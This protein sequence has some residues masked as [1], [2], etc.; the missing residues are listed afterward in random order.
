[1]SDQKRS[2]CRATR[3]LVGLLILTSYTQSDAQSQN[4]SAPANRIKTDS[5]VTIFCPVDVI[6]IEVKVRDPRGKEASSLGRDDFTIYENGVEQQ[7]RLWARIEGTAT[8]DEE[9]VYA[10]AYT[11]VNLY[12]GKFHRIRVVARGTDKRKLR[13]KLLSPKGYDAK[14]YLREPEST[15]PDNGMRP[16]A[17]QRSSHRQLG[18]SSV[19]CAAG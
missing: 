18:R 5:T 9:A 1:M 19:V 6:T 2:D 8:G 3:L 17:N 4:Q 12:D 11:P 15:P 16:T 13:V 7:I 14:E 10:M